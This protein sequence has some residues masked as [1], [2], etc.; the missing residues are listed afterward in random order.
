MHIYI[1]ILMSICIYIYT[2][3]MYMQ[4]FALFR[5][6][7]YRDLSPDVTGFVGACQP[8]PKQQGPEKHPQSPA[9]ISADFQ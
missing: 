3:L 9:E 7:L 6:F 2:L 8:L 1:Y 5:Y 4:S